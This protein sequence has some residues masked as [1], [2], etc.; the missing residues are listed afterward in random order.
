MKLII[1]NNFLFIFYFLLK[2]NMNT[3]TLNN[4]Q[5]LIDWANKQKKDIKSRNTNA[6]KKYCKKR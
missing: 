5:T 4:T 1:T 6:K 2:Y 3:T